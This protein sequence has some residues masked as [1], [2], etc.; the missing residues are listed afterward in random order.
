MPVP[1][2]PVKAW[3][4]VDADHEIQ[5]WSVSK[6]NVLCLGIASERYP[7]WGNLQEHGYRIARVEI[8]E[9]SDDE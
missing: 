5:L 9:V 2:N 4:V 6:N 7:N 3:A 1:S 8:R